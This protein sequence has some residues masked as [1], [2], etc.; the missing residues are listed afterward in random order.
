[1]K[2][3]QDVPKAPVFVAGY[4]IPGKKPVNTDSIEALNPETDRM[5]KGVFKNLEF[6]GQSA[7]I[8]MRLYKGQRM[9]NE[10]LFHDREYTIPLSI[11]RAINTRTSYQVHK[12]C[13]DDK[14]GENR[15]DVGQIVQRYQ[16][17]STEYL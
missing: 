15:K 6:P 7:K 10:V 5:V 16:F 17:I 2:K 12:N 14:T 3:T 13:I 8:T 11:A 4:E 1:M 9:F